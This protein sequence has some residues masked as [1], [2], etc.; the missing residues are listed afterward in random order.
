MSLVAN[1]GSCSKR[2]RHI[3]IR[4]FWMAE[5]V[6]DGSIEVIHCPTADMWANFLTKPIGGAQLAYERQGLTNWHN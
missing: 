3:D 4:Y 5:K 1:G 2:S 6:S